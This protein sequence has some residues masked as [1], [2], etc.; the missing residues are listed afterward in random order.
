ML[1]F[2]LILDH[3]FHKN[4]ISEWLVTHE[5]CPC[6]RHFF[7]FFVENDGDLEMF[8]GRSEQRPSN[9][10]SAS[11][12]QQA[13]QAAPQDG[14]EQRLAPSHGVAVSARSSGLASS[15]EASSIEDDSLE[16]GTRVLDRLQSESRIQ[17]DEPESVEVPTSYANSSRQG[18]AKSAEQPVD[19]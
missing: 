18:P 13:D 10:L 19:E 4:C 7:L 12:M 5:E 15:S 3:F 17:T 2:L 1:S 8:E 6:C 9:Q 14:S 11:E 16:R